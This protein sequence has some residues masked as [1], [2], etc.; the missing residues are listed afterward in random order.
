MRGAAT[1]RKK[2]TAGLQKADVRN[3]LTRVARVGIPGVYRTLFAASGRQHWWP[4]ESAFEIMVGAV[5]TQNTAWTN[6]EK[7]IANL[8]QVQAL[9]PQAIVKAHPHKLAGWLKSSGYFN[10]KAKR[11]RAFA[12][13]E[14][15]A[16]SGAEAEAAEAIQV[17]GVTTS[18]LIRP[19]SQGPRLEKSAIVSEPSA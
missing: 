6:V 16:S 3:R 11:L 15:S 7:A 5:L 8:K 1:A 9:S 10:I 2:S 14:T 4:G 18:G 13:H 17:P 19:S 12:L